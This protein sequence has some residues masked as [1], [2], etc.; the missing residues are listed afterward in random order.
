M[1]DGEYFVVTMARSEVRR[2][3]MRV[4]IRDFIVWIMTAW[5]SGCRRAK[6]AAI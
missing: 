4:S 1:R 5:D 2:S 6:A 3:W